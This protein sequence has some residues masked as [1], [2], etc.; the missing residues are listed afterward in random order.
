MDDE[1][2]IIIMISFSRPEE[3]EGTH[4]NIPFCVVTKNEYVFVICAYV[5]AYV[6]STKTAVCETS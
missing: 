1:A 6:N 2:Y 3:M 4:L 5:S